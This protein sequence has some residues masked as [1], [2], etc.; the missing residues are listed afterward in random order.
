MQKATQEEQAKATTEAKMAMTLQMLATADQVTAETKNV[1][2]IAVAL[3]AVLLAAAS[4]V[5]AQSGQ[6]AL[7]APMVG[8]KVAMHVAA[9]GEKRAFHSWHWVGAR[10][11]REKSC[12]TLRRGPAK[13]CRSR[14]CHLA[15]VAP[16]L[17]LRMRQCQR[18]PGR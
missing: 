8:R 18:V 17:V 13:P 16:K 3:S 12:R 5:A 4:S 2:P 6:V 14:A 10:F 7:V 15:Q 11:R 9:A 1:A